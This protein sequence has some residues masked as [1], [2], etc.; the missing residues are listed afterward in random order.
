VG[1]GNSL[2]SRSGPGGERL[3]EEEKETQKV[4]TADWEK[5]DAIGAGTCNTAWWD[6]LQAHKQWA[7]ELDVKPQSYLGSSFI[8][9]FGFCCC[10]M[11]SKALCLQAA[12][13]SLESLRFFTFLE[14]GG[15]VGGRLVTIGY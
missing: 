11:I 5:E 13:V 2:A 4:P 10:C 9:P 3:P 8:A 15:S 14:K 12:A 1:R 6:W 7:R